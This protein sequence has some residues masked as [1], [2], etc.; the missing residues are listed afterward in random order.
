VEP[1]ASRDHLRGFFSP[2]KVDADRT[3]AHVTDI[4]E[5]FDRWPSLLTWRNNIDPVAAVQVAG[6]KGSF[7]GIDHASFVAD[8]T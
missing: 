2:T 5:K 1:K 6:V 4:P 8:V 7:A 3:A